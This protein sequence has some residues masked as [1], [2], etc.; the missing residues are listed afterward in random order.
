MEYFSG[1]FGEFEQKYFAPPKICLLLHL[2]FSTLN[3]TN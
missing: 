3:V 1:K 2:C